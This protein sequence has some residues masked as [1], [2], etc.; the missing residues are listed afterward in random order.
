MP[1]QPQELRPGYGFAITSLTLGIL[2]ALF[3]GFVFSILGIVFGV[4]SLK[5]QGRDIGI[6]GLVLCIVMTVVRVV[7]TLAIHGIIRM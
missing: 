5:T 2:C 7:Q 4:L 3:L 6:A 1:D